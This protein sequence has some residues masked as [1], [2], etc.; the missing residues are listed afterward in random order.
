[1]RVDEYLHLMPIDRYYRVVFVEPIP[2]IDLDFG[3]FSA[4]QT[5]TGLELEN[6]YMPRNELAQY[7]MIPIDNVRIVGFRQPK[8]PKWITRNTSGYLPPQ[9]DY[10]GAAVENLNLTEW[11]QFEETKAYVDLYATSALTTSV[12]RFSGFRYVLEQVERPPVFTTVW[13]E[14]LAPK[15]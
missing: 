5:K 10:T 9:S 12:I 8:N 6:L 11:Y 15:G 4:G 3:A 2:A 7:R 14:A 1:V 13:Y